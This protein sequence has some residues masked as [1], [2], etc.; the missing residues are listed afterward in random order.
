VGA[1]TATRLSDP[2]IEIAGSMLY[3]QDPSIVAR[4][5]FILIRRFRIWRNPSGGVLEEEG[6]LHRSH[7][8]VH[9]G[10]FHLSEVRSLAQYGC[11]GSGHHTLL[12]CDPTPLPKMFDLTRSVYK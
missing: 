10:L 6:S 4:G 8:A 12:T 9:L 5:C 7:V 3:A 2:L 1:S 11:R